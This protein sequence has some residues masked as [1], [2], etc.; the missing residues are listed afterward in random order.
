MTTRNEQFEEL[1]QWVL[2]QRRERNKYRAA[3]AEFQTLKDFYL[4]DPKATRMGQ[5]RHNAWMKD[6]RTQD[7]IVGMKDAWASMQAAMSS[8]ECIRFEMTEKVEL[9][10]ALARLHAKSI[11]M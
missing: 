1:A 6:S 4:H 7:A 11:G 3:Y 2:I 8:I 5:D 9:Q 10:F